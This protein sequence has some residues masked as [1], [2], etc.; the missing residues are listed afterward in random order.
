MIYMA[1]Y[2]LCTTSNARSV[3]GIG[4][5]FSDITDTEITV[6]I[7]NAESYIYNNYYPVVRT[8]INI[9]N[10]ATSAGSLS[11]NIFNSLKNI[12]KFA[13]NI[14]CTSETQLK[15]YEDAEL[16]EGNLVNIH[17]YDRNINNATIIKVSD[18]SSIQKYGNLILS[19]SKGKAGYNELVEFNNDWN[20]LSLKNNTVYLI[21]I[22]SKDIDNIISYLISW[23]ENN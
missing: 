1:K 13:F 8:K 7:N 12:Q 18:N 2:S 22:L 4:S 3:A 21:E 15:I 17:N 23:E 9:D 14:S 19:L 11:L 20:K 16:E 10:Q 6:F 5:D